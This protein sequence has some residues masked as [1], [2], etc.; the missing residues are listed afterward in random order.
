[1]PVTEA[2]IRKQ[3]ERTALRFRQELFSRWNLTVVTV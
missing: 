1:L 2:G 3:G